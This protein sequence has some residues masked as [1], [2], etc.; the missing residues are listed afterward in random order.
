M[1]THRL[2]NYKAKSDGVQNS[3]RTIILLFETFDML[4]INFISL[5]N[6]FKIENLLNKG[7]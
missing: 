7:K 5:M 6:A 1:K 4:R 2:T 3:I